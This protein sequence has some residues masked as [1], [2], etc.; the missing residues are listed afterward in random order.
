MVCIFLCVSCASMGFVE[1]R[2]YIRSP[3]S[4]FTDNYELPCKCWEYHKICGKDSLCLS[5]L[6]HIS[7]PIPE[8]LL[9]S[10]SLAYLWLDKFL[11]ILFSVWYHFLLLTSKCMSSHLFFYDLPESIYLS[12][13]QILLDS[14][15]AFI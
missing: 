4:G 6:N 15:T 2:K 12:I 14:V 10:I 9:R 5:L 3:G 13:K 11:D 7:I 8:T 1:T